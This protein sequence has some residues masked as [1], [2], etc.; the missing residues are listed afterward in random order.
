MDGC[1]PVDLSPQ[2]P[3]PL[4]TH[5]IRILSAARLTALFAVAGEKGW[6]RGFAPPPLDGFALVKSTCSQEMYRR[7]TRPT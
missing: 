3:A 4:T 7:A 2:G 6:P 1:E 5:R